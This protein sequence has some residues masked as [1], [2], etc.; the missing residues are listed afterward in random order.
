MCIE[1]D[2][3]PIW[4]AKI[5]ASIIKDDDVKEKVI[6]YQ[7]KAKDVLKEAFIENRPPQTYLEALQELVKSEQQ[8]LIL[9]PKAEKY[10][11]F[12][13]GENLQKLGDVGKIVGMGRNRLFSFLR[14]QKIL[15][16]NNVPYQQ[17][18]DRGYFEVKETPVNMGGQ[19]INKPQTYATAKGVD[20][21]DSL[22][23]KKTA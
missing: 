3:L 23:Q 22:I 18:I 15:M 17:Y 13:S 12:I 9:Q 5:N 16:K 1:L 11:R 21:I 4:L 20:Y 14:E 19:T 8:K 6:K 7:L 10:D 2:F